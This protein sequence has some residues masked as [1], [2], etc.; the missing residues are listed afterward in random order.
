[1]SDAEPHL[2]I[3]D[4]VIGLEFDQRQQARGIGELR[5]EL[6]ELRKVVDGM[7]EADKIA[8]AVATA[9]RQDRSRWFN[10]WRRLGAAAGA[11]ILLV[12]AVHDAVAWLL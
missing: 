4:R 2:S 7:T 5:D 11:A 1:M 12:P 6:H 8:T 3:R 10:G 9:L